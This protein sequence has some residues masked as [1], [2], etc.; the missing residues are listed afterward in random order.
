PGFDLRSGW[1]VISAYQPEAVQAGDTMP[2]GWWIA[3]A[4]ALI[5]M[6][7][8]MMADTAQKTTKT[9]ITPRRKVR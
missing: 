2:K 9:K 5:G 3:L 8:T 6:A 1:G 4:A 7:G